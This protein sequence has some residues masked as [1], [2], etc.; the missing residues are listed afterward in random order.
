MLAIGTLVTSLF[1]PWA[2]WFDAH[3]EETL[4]NPER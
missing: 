3:R 1:I 2:W 4:Q